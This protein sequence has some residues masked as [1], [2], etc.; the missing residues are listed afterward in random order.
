MN[1]RK[2]WKLGVATLI[3]TLMAG[4]AAQ[5]QSIVAQ[6]VMQI[7]VGGPPGGLFDIA[8][9]I[10][11][12]RLGRE[13]GKTIVIENKPGAGTAVALAFVKNAKPD[14][15]TAAMINV[16]AAANESIIKN[17]GYNLLADF[18]PVGLYVYPANI[19]IANP[20]IGVDS[21]KGLVEALQKRGASANYS[22]GGIGSPGHL[23]GEMFKARF[24]LQ[25]TH[26]P[27]KGAPPAVLAVVQGDVDY[28][29]ATASS[30]A[31]QIAADKVRALAVTTA[32]RLPQFS[33]VP[34]MVEAGLS[35]FSVSD[36]VGFLL[37]KGTSAAVRDKLHAALVAA[38]TDAE[39]SER[40]RKATFIPIASPLGPVEFDAFLR[41]EVD[42]W[43]KVVTE[44]KI[45]LQ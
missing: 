8:L 24:G 34:T 42:K 36:W 15:L 14:G 22:S 29:F 30:A 20:A 3:A 7:V 31:G 4:G 18:V 17:R 21:V 32:E 12:E 5:S 40:L 23:A 10:V 43:A 9:R 35:G 1:R 44:A 39:N 2:A 19:L 13:L 38:F 41:S 25:A 37:P 26:V 6:P 33:G 11:S 16:S 27:Y 45:S 28:M